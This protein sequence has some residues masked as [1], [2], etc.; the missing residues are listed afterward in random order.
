MT[1]S[2]KEEHMPH[3]DKHGLCA[4]CGATTALY[5]DD[6]KYIC[7]QCLRHKFEHQNGEW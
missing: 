3:G 1:L 6:G 5:E 2:T 7:E 4:E